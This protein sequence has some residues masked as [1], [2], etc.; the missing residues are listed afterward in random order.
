MTTPFRGWIRWLRCRCPVPSA[1]FFCDLLL[2]V[3]SKDS[4]PFH[5]HMHVPL[6]ASTLRSISILGEDKVLRGVEHMLNWLMHRNG[7][8]TSNILEGG[9]FVDSLNPG[10]PD[11]QLIFLPVL[12]NV[13]N[14]SG[15]APP[16]AE[17]GFTV[18]VR[19]LLPKHGAHV[20]RQRMRH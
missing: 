10:R 19:H 4:S 14:P 13:N 20:H 8:L 16:A 9:G 7:L 17:Y 6:N 11:V 15:K 5:D 18:K 12:D 3:G 2:E 1:D